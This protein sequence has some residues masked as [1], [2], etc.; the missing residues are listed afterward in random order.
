M[1]DVLIVGGGLAGSALA[2]HLA[3]QGQRVT[4]LDR[5]AFPREKACGEG[6][7]P[8][9][10]AALARLGID[11]PSTSFR[12]VRYRC[13][14]QVVSGVFPDGQVGMGVRRN[15]LD[16]ALWNAA[17]AEPNVHAL[18]RTAVDTVLYEGSSIAGVIAN[19]VEYRARLTV[20]ADGANSTMRHKLGWDASP[21]SRRFGLCRHFRLAKGT[22]APAWVDAFLYPYREIYV[23]P[24]PGEELLVAVLR[25]TNMP[26]PLAPEIQ[27][28]LQ[29]AA[30]I[31]TPLGASPLTV[32]ARQR[33]GPGC[34]L[35]G[36][37]AGNCDPITGGGMSQALLSAELLARHLKT[38]RLDLDAFDREREAMLTDYRRLTAGVLAMAHRPALTRVALTL[39][40]ASPPLFS[41]LMGV[42][43]GTRSLLP[44][45]RRAA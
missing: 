30:E 6:L 17:R 34:V 28:L 11:V 21:P 45:R 33:V 23:T 41:H 15:V 40:Q 10:V 19:G 1:T 36:D 31:G 18:S 44:W 24:L 8:A 27:M 35:L 12:G 43:G 14:T 2:I 7:M 37:A 20:A 25:D 16:A 3:R 5:S 22:S 4:L 38:S 29:G 26:E 9:G 13:G 42:A 32:S 39:L